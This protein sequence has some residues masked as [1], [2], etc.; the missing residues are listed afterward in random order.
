MALSP[1]DPE[2]RRLTG[3]AYY[4]EELCHIRSESSR[5][6]A[7][8]KRDVRQ[9]FVRKVYGILFC[10]LLLTMLLTC[11][12]LKVSSLNDWVVAHRLPLLISGLV[13][14]LFT[15]LAMMCFSR[16]L[17]HFPWNYVLLAVF[18]VSMTL[19]IASG[20]AKSDGRTVLLALC[21][22]LLITGSMTLF[23]FQT[24]YDF[25]SAIGGM[26]VATLA[27]VCFG[28]FALFMGSWAKVLYSTLAIA[29]FS[30][31]LVIDTQLMMS[32]KKSVA[33]TEDDYIL[34]SVSLY[35][36]IINIFLELHSLL[37]S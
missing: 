28:L 25:T 8:W 21:G 34:A 24:K 7:D 31:W 32:G 10:Q 16:G 11:L 3:G 4:D 1:D 22:T 30:G 14:Y 35:T 33:Y 23:A 15:T 36:D 37:S 26:F 12:V 20:V 6:V 2:K 18:T 27:L 13:G 17:R 29:L 19:M 5:L 9:G